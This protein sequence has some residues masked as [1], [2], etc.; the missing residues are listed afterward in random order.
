MLI[1][2]NKKLCQ[3]I[4]SIALLYLLHGIPEMKIVVLNLKLF[5]NKVLTLMGNPCIKYY[6]PSGW[7]GNVGTKMEGHYLTIQT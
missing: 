3:S 4:I 2:A 1:L 6:F 7:L 5:H